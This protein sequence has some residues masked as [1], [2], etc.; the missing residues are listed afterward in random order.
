MNTSMTGLRAWLVQ[1]ITALY[2]AL[3]LVYALVHLTL[4]PPMSFD[5]WRA[6]VSHPGVSV[7]IA[8]FFAALLLHA[9]IGI[10][11]VILD[12]VHNVAL[13]LVVLVGVGMVLVAQGLWVLRVLYGV[14]S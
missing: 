9:W 10:R 5:D 7:A 8:L 6:W 12:Y 4:S 14:N 13:R 11:D 2:L 3:F 1:R